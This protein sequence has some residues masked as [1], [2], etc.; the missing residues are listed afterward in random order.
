MQR[1]IRV[2]VVSNGNVTIKSRI[3]NYLWN[4]CVYN[5][6]FDLFCIY[7][8]KSCLA[9]FLYLTSLNYN[10]SYNPIQIPHWPAFSRTTK[11]NVTIQNVLCLPSCKALQDSIV[12]GNLIMMLYLKAVTCISLHLSINKALIKMS[13]CPNWIEHITK[14]FFLQC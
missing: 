14:L 10:S 12:L 6:H 4:V 13:L 5:F 1:T 3:Y 7:V 8:L 2:I 11:F 9:C